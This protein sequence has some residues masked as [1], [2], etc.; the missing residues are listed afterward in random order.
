M[1]RY[2]DQTSYPVK[3]NP[4]GADTHH[5]V[6]EADGARPNVTVT[7]TSVWDAAAAADKNL[8][9]AQRASG[10]GVDPISSASGGVLELSGLES[11]SGAL[12][13]LV[14]A[15]RQTVNFEPNFGTI[16]GTVAEGDAAPA[17]Q[18]NL[19]THIGD[20]TNPHGVTAAQAGAD[21]SGSAAAV[22]TNLDTHTG[23]T[24]IHYADAPADGRP[25][26]R[27]NNVWVDVTTLALTWDKVQTFNNNP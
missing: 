2:N 27:V 11:Q 14:D 24:S 10:N 9:T 3:A 4:T 7:L 19:T 17:V 18:T 12:S 16:A 5:V 23:T 1:A 26:V 21:P 25:Y 20:A 6:D 15:P 13:V 8:Q 22:Q